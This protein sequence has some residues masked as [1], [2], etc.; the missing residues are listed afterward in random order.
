MPEMCQFRFNFL[1]ETSF[2]SVES[3]WK[4]LEKIVFS[5]FVL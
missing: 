4:D 3:N 5:K 2:F 1:D